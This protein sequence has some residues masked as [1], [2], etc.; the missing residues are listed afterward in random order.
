M[1]RRTHTMEDTTPQG[2]WR[3]PHPKY[4]GGN[5]LQKKEEKKTEDN[6]PHRGT[7]AHMITSD[8]R[9]YTAVIRK[10]YRGSTMS[11]CHLMHGGIYPLGP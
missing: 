4:N 8:S 3:T 6:G 9:V 11:T 2:S 10:P 7:I 1:D 5:N